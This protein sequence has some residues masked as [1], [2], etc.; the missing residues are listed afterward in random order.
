M[1]MKYFAKRRIDGKFAFAK[2]M[3][4]ISTEFG[5]KEPTI[6]LKFRINRKEGSEPHI[7]HKG[8]DIYKYVK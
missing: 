8:V 2:S 3:V 1:D 4:G 7:Y 5:L 6:A